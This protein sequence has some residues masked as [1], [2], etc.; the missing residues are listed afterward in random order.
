MYKKPTKY[1]YTSEELSNY[2]EGNDVYNSS[3][4]SIISNSALPRITY[5]I[6]EY[7]YRPDLIANEIYGSSSYEGILILQ[8]GLTLDKFQKGRK[9]EVLSK[10]TLDT[11]LFNL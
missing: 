4:L 2:I 5:V 3:F 8:T 6:S 11:I 9:I 1:T 10:T 7:E